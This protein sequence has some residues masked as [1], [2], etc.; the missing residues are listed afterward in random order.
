MM[1]VKEILEVMEEMLDGAPTV[2]L[3]G[4]K[5]L[6]DA[7]RLRELITDIRG[8]LPV[9]LE[10][11]KQTLSDRQ[12]ILSDAT[13][14]ANATV[15]AA[16]ERARRLV[17]EDAITRQVKDQAKELMMTAMTQSK[18]LK[19]AANEYADRTL[20]AAEQGLVD[21]I[22][23]LRTAKAALRALPQK[24]QSVQKPQAPNNAK[25]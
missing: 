3:S 25:Q 13:E 1:E 16:E 23:Q 24:D 12:R 10:T 5:C 6:I 19:N 20:K 8:N 11:A 18:E 4:G 2:P 17:D 15:K 14:K 22:N 21:S 9:E 7:E